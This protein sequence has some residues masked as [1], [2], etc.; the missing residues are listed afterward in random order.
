MSL[1]PKTFCGPTADTRGTTRR[2]KTPGGA[3]PEPSLIVIGGSAGSIPTV[4]R[5]LKGLP[6]GWRVPIVILVHTLSPL[7]DRW[8]AQLR[9]TSAINVSE[10]EDQQPLVSGNVYI[11]PFNF[12][13]LVD[14]DLCLHLDYSEQ[15]LNARPSID[16]LFTSAGQVYRQQLLAV[17]LSG[18]NSDGAR[19]LRT[20]ASCGGTTIVQ[21][22]ADSEF[23]TMP[24]AA[25]QCMRPSFVYTAS[26]LLTYF[27][28]LGDRHRRPLHDS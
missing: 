5:I 27:K 7:P 23:A 19:G 18:A 22:P 4:L 3:P 12:H 21:D 14:K 17:L 8:L 25:L 2:N 10:A 9:A 20:V 15:V 16:V 11:A 24:T 13:L 26:R 1:M 28:S 6:H